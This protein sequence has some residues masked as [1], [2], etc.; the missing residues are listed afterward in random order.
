MKDAWTVALATTVV[1]MGIE[2]GA[3]V[4]VAVQTSMSVILVLVI[5]LAGLWWYWLQS[6]TFLERV[7]R[8]LN[9]GSSDVWLNIVGMKINV[10][11]SDRFE[12][13]PE[14]INVTF[15]DVKG[16]SN[17]PELV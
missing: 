14:E 8:R 4:P 10:L 3:V 2:A 12:V 15:D 6:I 17:L 16:V 1:C 13:N 5:N 11:K 9:P 7:L